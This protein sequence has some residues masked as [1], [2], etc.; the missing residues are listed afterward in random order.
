MGDE[1]NDIGSILKQA[2]ERQGI[3][4]DVLHEATKIPIDSLKAI[5]EGYKVRTLSPFY[6]KSFVKTYSQ[7]VG[8]DPQEMLAKISSSVPVEVIKK[9]QTPSKQKVSGK[10]QEKVLLVLA[11]R[12]LGN[13][14][15][16]KVAKI[17]FV[18]VGVVLL[19]VALFFVVK[20]I[21]HAIT[22]AASQ[23]RTEMK[24]K[25]VKKTEQNKKET[26]K[27]TPVETAS[28]K[29]NEPQAPV[30]PAKGSAGPKEGAVIGEG[31]VSAKNGKTAEVTV[32]AKMNSW[33]S[34]KADGQTVFRQ[35]LK[36]GS[37]ETWRASKKIEI[38]GKDVD[39]LEFE[40]NGK[41]IGKLSRRD[42]KARKVVVTPEGLT[43]E[44]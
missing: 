42:V 35:I 32:R 33:L 14:S 38:S 15:G 31:F 6:Y 39:A 9:V 40:V 12:S 37:S 2:R 41:N 20:K 26:V 22:V 5:E 1:N 43:V 30:E 4:L 10:V 29:K 28:V 25:P 17:F 21:Q 16:K 19:G 24:I 18:G 44:K 36:K 3:S 8:L 27:S 23:P 11:A 7:Y 13:R 34:V